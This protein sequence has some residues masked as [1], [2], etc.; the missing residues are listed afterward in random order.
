MAELHIASGR[1]IFYDVT[2]NGSPLL[3]L[4]GAGES[5]QLWAWQLP[6]FAPTFRV[7]TMDNRDSGASEPDASPYSVADLANDTVA[8]LDA[9]NLARAHVL[10]TSMGSMIALQLALDHPARIDRLVLM[11]PLAGGLQLSAPPREAWS[12]DHADWIRGMFPMLAAPGYFD[13]HPG[14]LEELVEVGRENRLTYEGVVHQID[15][16]GAFDVRSRLPE[17]TAPTL[18]VVGDRDPFIPLTDAQA[19]ATALPNA[20][21]VTIAGAGHLAFLEDAEE[22]NRVV[23]DFLGIEQRQSAIGG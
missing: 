5:R 4:M 10:G 23:L 7:I 22:V 9:L 17:I 2:G 21:L 15:A 6:A 18:L 20:Q 13:T 11:S 16:M 3:L 8:L 1:R 14:A 12:T 19:F